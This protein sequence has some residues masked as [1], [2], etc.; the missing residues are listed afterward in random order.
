MQH[1]CLPFQI[2]KHHVVQGFDA[3]R[4]GGSVRW[5]L[6]RTGGIAGIEDGISL[7]WSGHTFRLSLTLATISYVKYSVGVKGL[8]HYQLLMQTRGRFNGAHLRS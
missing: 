6:Y 5:G 8:S 4:G 2:S 3:S 1:Q 7:L